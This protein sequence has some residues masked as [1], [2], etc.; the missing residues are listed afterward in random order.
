MNQTFKGKLN[1]ITGST[2]PNKKN[3]L[4]G[5]KINAEKGQ[6]AKMKMNNSPQEYQDSSNQ[7][8]KLLRDL[9]P[10]ILKEGAKE[11]FQKMSKRSQ[12]KIE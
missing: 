1:T 11:T 12:Q 3:N 6:H 4:E 8:N 7:L 2:A 9:G 5:R 10:V